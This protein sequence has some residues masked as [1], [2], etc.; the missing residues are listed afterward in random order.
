VAHLLRWIQQ[1]FY[2]GYHLRVIEPGCV[3]SGDDLI[4]QERR[5]PRWT[6]DRVTRATFEHIDDEESYEEL[7]ALLLS[8]DWKNRMRVLRGRWVARQ[9]SNGLSL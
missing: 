1:S 2:T 6:V 7:I 5:Y 3:S 4:L 8:A 9:Q